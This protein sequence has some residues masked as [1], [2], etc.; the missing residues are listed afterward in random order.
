MYYLKFFCFHRYFI[1]I[2]LFST[3]RLYPVLLYSRLVF[4]RQNIF[5]LSCFIPDWIY[6]LQNV[7]ILSYFIPDWCFIRKKKCLY[8]VLLYSRLVFLYS[9]KRLYA[10]LLSSR[11]FLF[12][13]TSLSCPT[14]FQTVIYLFIYFLFCKTSLSCPPSDCFVLFGKTSLSC[15]TLF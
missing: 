8:S 5:I 7:F 1:I 2:S 3:E 13:K 6:I 10:V 12:G 9:A 11:L 15:P 4:I 14:V